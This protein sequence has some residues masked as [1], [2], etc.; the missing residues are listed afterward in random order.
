MKAALLRALKR[1]AA[2]KGKPRPIP[3]RDGIA[4]GENPAPSHFDL[5]P[6]RC[7]G[8][9]HAERQR[10]GR[11]HRPAVEQQWQR[12]FQ[13]DHPGQPLG[14][15]AAGQQPNRRFGQAEP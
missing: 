5:L 3:A 6:S 2:G 14:T 11:R 7:D 10:L 15:A 1:T 4:A 12:L 8:I 13:A 9:D